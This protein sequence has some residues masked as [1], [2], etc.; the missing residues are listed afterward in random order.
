[1][2]GGRVRGRL[3]A[4]A[5]IALV[6][7]AGCTNDEPET[8]APGSTSSTRPSVT[9]P[10]RDYSKV[11][12][13]G[14]EGVTTTS[15]GLR[16]GK[17]R[18]S[19]QVIGPRGT[20]KGAIVEITRMVG[21]AGATERIVT[22]EFGAWKAP[23]LLGGRYRVRA[24]RAPDFALV[25]PEIFFLEEGE[26]RVLRIDL[27]DYTGLVAVASVAPD[28]PPLRRQVRLV[29]KVAQRRVDGN[30]VVVSQ[31]IVRSPVEIVPSDSWSFDSPTSTTT[32]DAGVARWLAQCSRAGL[33]PLT[34]VVGGTETVRFSPSSCGVP[35]P[36]TAPPEG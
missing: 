35:P 11:Q 5:V 36:T 13:A 24:W 23:K 4:G 22:G 34:L 12:L 26:Q 9:T 2:T 19:G 15:I 3:L 16:P 28:P 10:A 33:H 6:V 29:V 14:V 17:A 21:S 27:T 32:N 30:G 25:E 8:P 1:M 20:V 7:A 31:P 18:L